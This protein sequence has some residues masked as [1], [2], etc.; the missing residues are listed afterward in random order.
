[1]TD[2]QT[3]LIIKIIYIIGAVMI[4][5]GAIFKIQHYQYGNSILIFGFVIESITS[6]YDNSRLKKRIKKMEEQINYKN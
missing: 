2:T 6:S 1:M 5:T 4:I 3:N